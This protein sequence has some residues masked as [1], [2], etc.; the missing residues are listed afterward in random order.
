MGCSMGHPLEY[1]MVFS[2]SNKMSAIYTKSPSDFLWDLS[3]T[4]GPMA[5]DIPWD[6]SWDILSCKWALCGKL[7]C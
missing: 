1:P 3:S 5:W 6:V 2:K 4:I 7:F